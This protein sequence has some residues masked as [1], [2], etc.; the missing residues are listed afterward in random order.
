LSAT[1]TNVTKTGIIT[2]F[3]TLLRTENFPMSILNLRICLRALVLPIRMVT[4]IVFSSL[5]SK[6][7]RRTMPLVI[8]LRSILVRRYFLFAPGDLLLPWMT[9]PL[10]SKSQISP[11]EA[12]AWRPKVPLSFFFST[13]NLS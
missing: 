5:V 8:W 1:R 13:S 4:Q 12:S 11:P 2:G 7:W 6:N 3:I 10:L 9:S